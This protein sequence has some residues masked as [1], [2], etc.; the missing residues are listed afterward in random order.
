ME[1]AILLMR[2][3]VFLKIWAAKLVVFSS[4]TVISRGTCFKKLNLQKCFSEPFFDG[5]CLC[6]VNLIMA[7]V[8]LVKK[9][10]PFHVFFL[11]LTEITRRSCRRFSKVER[12]KRCRRV[13][14]KVHF[15]RFAKIKIASAPCKVT[16]L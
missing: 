15:Y 2:I 4:K 14:A 16:V 13:E 7:P 3:G 5:A 1:S 12:C 6:I 11:I 10:Y 8:F 9:R